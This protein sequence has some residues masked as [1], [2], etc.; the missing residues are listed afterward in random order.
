MKIKTNYHTHTTYC[1]GKDN[2]EQII[3]VAL[4]KGFSILGFSGHTINPLAADWHISAKEIDSYVKEIKFLAQKY[5]NQIEIL[6]GFEVDYLPPFSIPHANTYENLAPDYLIGSV[7]Y[8]VGDN[9]WFTV[10]GPVEEVSDGI[11]N[12]F[13]GNGKLA[14]QAYFS[15]QREMLLCGKFDIIGHI[16]VIRKRNPVLQFFDETEPWY[17]RELKETAK[18]IA[19]ADVIVEINTG[20][21]LRGAKDAYPSVDFLEIIHEQNIPIMVNSDAHLAQNLD[22]G[23][24]FAY[25][26]ALE[27]GYK[28]LVSLKSDG[29]KLCRHFHPLQDYIS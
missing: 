21:L 5:I 3:S 29:K 12:L 20:G 22:M 8:I 1:D 10:D 27:A 4:D 6:C 24:D 25:K 18:A 15:L 23:F 19:K 13:R 26:R 9:G 14:V 2:P 17:R 11:K 7:H 16:D 28:E